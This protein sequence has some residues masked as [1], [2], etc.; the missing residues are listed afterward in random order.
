MDRSLPTASDLK[1]I[2]Q[3]AGN[4][5][6]TC[7]GKPLER[8]EK[9]DQGFVTEADRASELFLIGA[10]QTLFPAAIVAEESGKYGAGDYSWVI[11]PLDGTTNFFR[12]LSYF[13]ISVAL[14]YEQKPI[15]GAIYQPI[16]DEFFYASVSGGAFLNGNHISVSAP[17]S[18][19]KSLIAVGF[20]Y[21]AELRVK[22]FRV[23]QQVAQNAFGIRHFGSIALNMANLA[24]GRLDGIIFSNLCWW[25]V[26]AGIILIQEAGGIVTDF[27]GKLLDPDYTTGIA[28]GKMVYNELKRLI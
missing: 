10:L 2:L 12:H 26:A 20:S 1:P 17:V 25:D 21:D 4:I 19:D 11:D 9:E 23:A 27:G 15:I 16:T 28:G 22:M 14:V 5:L 24:A 3:Q 13:C 6:K 7:Y 18:F 8:T